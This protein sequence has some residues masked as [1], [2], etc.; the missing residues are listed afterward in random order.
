MKNQLIIECDY[1]G[2]LNKLER[3]NLSVMT[4]S[5]AE[6]NAT[7]AYIEIKIECKCGKEI[8][9]TILI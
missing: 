9:E 3:E 2:C 7:N 1:C 8:R 4:D 5:L 6:G